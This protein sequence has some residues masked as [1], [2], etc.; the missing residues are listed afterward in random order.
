MNLDKIFSEALT[1]SSGAFL[2]LI[3]QVNKIL[4]REE[5]GIG[6]LN[7]VGRLIYVPP[8]G[9]AII[10]GDI[11]GDL[12]SLEQIL[13]RTEIMEKMLSGRDAYLIFLGDYGDRGV[14]SPEVYYVVLLLKK[15]F[16]RNVILLQG[17]HEGPEDL[18]AYPHDLPY[19]LRRKFGSEWP[20][21]YRDLSSLFR[22]FYTAVL[23]RDRYVM[24]HGGVPSMARSIEDVAFAYTK[25]PTESHLEEILW[26]DPI[27]DMEGTYP[28]PRGA[29][30]LFGEDVTRRFLKLLGVKFLIRGHEPADD[31]YKLNHGGT[32]LT[33]FSRKGPPYYNQNAAYITLDL[34]LCPNS[35]KDIKNFIQKF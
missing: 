14:Y 30:Y 26:S 11:H 16:P 9:E 21:I 25:H 20:V 18:L 27:D 6:N 7:I 5:S 31:G 10:I 15:L 35:S 17:N 24:L 29:G 1:V 19:H 8:T 23:V 13:Y 2:N 33:L 22:R 12:Q 34:S 28:S 32:V 3:D 4:S